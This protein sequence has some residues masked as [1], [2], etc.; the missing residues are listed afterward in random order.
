MHLAQQERVCLCTGETMKLNPSPGKERGR[1]PQP[2]D[3]QGAGRIKWLWFPR[4]FDLLSRCPYLIFKIEVGV[5][6]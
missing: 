1:A 5:L 4:Q 3:N 2:Q 6:T